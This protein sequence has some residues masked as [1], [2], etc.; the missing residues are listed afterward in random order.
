MTTFDARIINANVKQIAAALF[1]IFLPVSNVNQRANLLTFFISM[2]CPFE[3]GV[4]EES[5]GA[6]KALYK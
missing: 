2:L 3:I 4:E 5:W 6:I 1:I